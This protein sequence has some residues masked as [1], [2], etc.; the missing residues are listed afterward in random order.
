MHNTTISINELRYGWTV[1]FCEWGHHKITKCLYFCFYLSACLPPQFY[2]V[3]FIYRKCRDGWFTS[4][5]TKLGD[6][7]TSWQKISF[8]SSPNILWIFGFFQTNLFLCKNLLWQLLET[9]WLLFFPTSGHTVY[10]LQLALS[11]LSSH[12]SPLFSREIVGLDAA[13]A[14]A[15]DHTWA[16]ELASS[17]AIQPAREMKSSK[18]A[19]FAKQQ[20]DHICRNFALWQNLKVFGNFWGLI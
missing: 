7:E 1:Q 8:K 19:H 10:I 9:I 17:L 12:D 2:L 13:C 14:S 20:N 3:L 15:R 16:S 5:V 6:F 11:Y 18:A 4:S